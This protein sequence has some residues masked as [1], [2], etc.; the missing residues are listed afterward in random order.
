MTHERLPADARYARDP[1]FRRMVDGVRAVLRAR[2]MTPTEVREAAVLA[3]EMHEHETVRRTWPL[4][5]P[6]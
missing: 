3:C 6:R 5:A 4:E 1:L 2:A